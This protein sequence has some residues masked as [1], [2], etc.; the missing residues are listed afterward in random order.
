M[1]I[2]VTGHRP[3]K[4]GG[5]SDE[6]YVKIV[7]LANFFISRLDKK[8]VILTGMAQGWDQAVAAAC[9]N[10]QIEYIACIPFRGQELLWSPASQ[11]TYNTLMSTSS[12]TIV[13]D[14]DLDVKT[15]N[16]PW[17]ISKAM[18]DR[19]KYMI[20]NCQHVFALWNSSKGGTANTIK[21]AKQKN[22]EITNCWPTFQAM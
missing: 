2:A 21:Y 10:N 1:I 7:N 15:N 8:T 20:D 17:K 9:L 3:D 13:I 18:Q 5:Y 19:N 4:L 12:N 6:A 22:I 11:K 14:E 16:L